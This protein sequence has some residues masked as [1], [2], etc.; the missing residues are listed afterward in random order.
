MSTMKETIIKIELKVAT[1]RLEK[2]KNIAPK[3]IVEN[4]KK[5]IEE[6]QE[7]IIKIGGDKSLLD[8]EDS[9]YVVKNGVGGK[10]YL[11][12]ENG[13]IYFPQAQYGKFISSKEQLGKA[14]FILKGR[15]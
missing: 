4:T 12:F 5:Y 1:E 8:K 14:S 11:E 15:E 10:P 13:I 2:L 3:I 6:L 9:P 7:G